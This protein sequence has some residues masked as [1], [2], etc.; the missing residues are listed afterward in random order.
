MVA[1]LKKK[2]WNKLSEEDFL[3]QV[4]EHL[5]KIVV[6]K[7]FPCATSQK[8]EIVDKELLEQYWRV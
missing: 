8:E 5:E 3:T 2:N 4:R 1:G 6:D 7:K